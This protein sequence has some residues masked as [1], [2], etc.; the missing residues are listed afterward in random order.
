MF[1]DDDADVTNSYMTDIMD[2]IL[3]YEG[4]GITFNQH[5][6]FNEGR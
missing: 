4:D 3:G 5:C 6:S 1:I 2:A